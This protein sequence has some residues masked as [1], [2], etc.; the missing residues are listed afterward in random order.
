MCYGTSVCFPESGV[1]RDLVVVV[2]G[3]KLSFFGSGKGRSE[4]P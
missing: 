2:E 1:S 4:R 3:I